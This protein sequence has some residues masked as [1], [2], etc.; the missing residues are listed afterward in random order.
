M[1]GEKMKNTETSSLPTLEK[2]IKTDNVD[3]KFRRKRLRDSVIGGLV[4]TGICSPATYFSIQDIIRNG[5]DF[6]D[7]AVGAISGFIGLIGLASTVSAIKTRGCL[8][9]S[10]RSNL[11]GYYYVDGKVSDR[12]TLYEEMHGRPIETVS[13]LADLKYEGTETSQPIRFIDHLIMEGYSF[14][15]DCITEHSD[16]HIREK[17]AYTGHIRLKRLEKTISL[18]YTFLTRID[19]KFSELLGMSGKE[20]SL[21]YTPGEF[22]ED[23]DQQYPFSVEKIYCP[24]P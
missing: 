1:E 24:H 11:K 2:I 7:T 3:E 10:E 4:V 17:K 16:K 15:E 13:N 18:P 21:L 22:D 9:E 5:F 19:K 20:F 8:D 12:K 23:C 6:C 14:N